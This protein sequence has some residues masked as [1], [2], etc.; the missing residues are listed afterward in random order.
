MTKRNDNGPMPGTLERGLAAFFRTVFP[1]LLL[2]LLLLALT[3]VG[4]WSSDLEAFDGG[5]MVEAYSCGLPYGDARPER[6]Q[7]V[8]RYQPVGISVLPFGWWLLLPLF[9]PPSTPQLPKLPFAT[10]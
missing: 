4:V 3:G 6:H 7:D 2:G 9:R 10:L 8:Y 1:S 5:D